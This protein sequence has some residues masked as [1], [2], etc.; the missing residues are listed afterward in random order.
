MKK[1]YILFCVCLIIILM[2][3][4]IKK[5]NKIYLSNK[6]YNEGGFIQVES[7]DNLESDNY[8]LY[9]Y[10][11]YC[12]FKIPCETIFKSVM[13]KYKLDVVSIPFLKYKNTN[14]YKKV[15]Y[16]PSIIII[17]K[18]RVKSYLDANKDS[19]VSK[20]Q[21]EVEFEKW[22]NNYIYLSK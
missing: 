8:L 9:V 11:D 6:Y 3:C 19:D 21:D 12:N 7:L 22:L 5:D 15:K 10:N 1:W 4:F 20:Y 2:I 13:N 14:L 16:A 17:E 18:G